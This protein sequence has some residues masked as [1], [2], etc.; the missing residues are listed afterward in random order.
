MP[1][2]RLPNETASKRGLST[3]VS[4]AVMALSSNRNESARKE[5]TASLRREFATL[6]ELTA[7]RS[8]PLYP[9]LWEIAYPRDRCAAKY[10]AVV[11]YTRLTPSS[12]IFSLPSLQAHTCA[13]PVDEPL[14]PNLNATASTTTPD[15]GLLSRK[16]KYPFKNT[17]SRLLDEEFR[18]LGGRAKRWRSSGEYKYHSFGD[19]D[20][21]DY[22]PKPYEDPLVRLLNDWD[23]R[24][25][26]R[27]NTDIPTEVIFKPSTPPD[28]MEELSKFLDPT[29]QFKMLP[30]P[31]RRPQVVS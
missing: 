20:K 29:S 19:G 1:V 4:R 15:A 8:I 28:L 24:Y 23:K 16:R 14:I 10:Q 18:D 21:C 6:S 25:P 17:E 13:V 11:S 30:L 3:L 2:A 12:T 9:P 26:L 5:L 7:L 31:F 22:I 27:N